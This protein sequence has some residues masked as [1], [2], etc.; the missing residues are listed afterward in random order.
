MRCCER[1][2]AD[3]SRLGGACVRV[4]YRHGVFC[5]EE[6]TLRLCGSRYFIEEETILLSGWLQLFDCFRLCRNR[7]E[8]ADSVVG[9]S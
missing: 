7:F 8:A 1:P 6:V 9:K 3:A 5:L 2:L 4:V